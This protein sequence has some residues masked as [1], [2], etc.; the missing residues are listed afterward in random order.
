[1]RAHGGRRVVATGL[2]CAEVG[3]HQ[4]ATEKQRKTAPGGCRL[5][6]FSCPEAGA[7]RRHSR[8]FGRKRPRDTAETASLA[9]EGGFELAVPPCRIFMR[10]VEP[11][12]GKQA[13]GAP[14]Q[15]GVHPV[16]PR[17]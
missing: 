7:D 4:S 6:P 11:G 3:L 8:D 10:P 12:A 1:P 13:D 16:S 17:I 5:V 9:E 2:S 14:V 15:P